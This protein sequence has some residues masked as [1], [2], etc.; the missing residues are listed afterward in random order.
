MTRS[1]TVT[2][3]RID[4]DAGILNFVPFARPPVD[5]NPPRTRGARIP[6]LA[7]CRFRVR[8]NSLIKNGAARAC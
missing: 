7:A 8:V 1:F 2:T 4:D 3:L 6:C 5:V